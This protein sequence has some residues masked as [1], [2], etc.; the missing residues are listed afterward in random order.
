MLPNLSGEEN[1]EGGAPEPE[2]EKETV[3]AAE[4]AE[5]AEVE[6]EVNQEGEE[7]KQNGVAVEEP[8]SPAAKSPCGN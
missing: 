7:E 4:A 6:C 2:M 5:G 3:E 8:P 1:G